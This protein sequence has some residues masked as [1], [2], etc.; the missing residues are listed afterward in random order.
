MALL[1]G[2]LKFLEI[3]NMTQGGHTHPFLGS[4]IGQGIPKLPVV[5]TEYSVCLV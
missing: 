4:S 3:S 2:M 5:R 1:A